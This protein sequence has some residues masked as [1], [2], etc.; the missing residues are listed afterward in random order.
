MPLTKLCSGKVRELYDAGDGL[1][2]MVASDRIS[3]FD[4]V[5]P[6]AIPDKGRVLT[7]MT[8]HWATALADLAP[9]HLV[10]AD[11]GD[12][13]AGVEVLEDVLGG[14]VAGRAMV[15]RRAQMLPLECI[16][17]GYLAGSA[18]QE[19]QRTGTVHGLT[20]PAGLARAERLPE[21]IFTPSTKASGGHDQN[22]SFEEACALVGRPLAEQAR[23]L[24]LEAYRRAAQVAEAQ[25]IL[26]ADTKFELGLIDG[27]LALCDEILT[28]DSSRFWPADAWSPGTNPPSFDKQPVRDW[29]EA[30]GWDKQPPPP[31]LPVEV[32]R[33]TAERYRTAYERICGKRLSDWYGA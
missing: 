23:E 17:R 4:T 2:L 14:P 16:V 15:V 30:S 24:C 3:A 22:I 6:Q 13:P 1:L 33:A 20:L 12:L 18:Y 27:Q 29:L 25:G 19:Y 31:D 21:P 9:S 11:P 10:S 7:A 5:L 32:V 8:V 26:L 28:P